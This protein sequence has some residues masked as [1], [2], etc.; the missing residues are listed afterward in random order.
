MSDDHTQEPMI[1][2][3]KPDG[4]SVRVP[5][6][7]LQKPAGRDVDTPTLQHFHTAT[8]QPLD[9]VLTNRPTGEGHVEQKMLPPEPPQTLLEES[10]EDDELSKDLG[11]TARQHYNTQTPPPVVLSDTRSTQN[12]VRST[13]QWSAIDHASPLTETLDTQTPHEV[14]S[15]RGEDQVAAFLTTMSVSI[16]PE[17]RGRTIALLSSFLKGIRSRQQVLGYAVK[18]VEIGGLQLSDVEA[19]SLVQQAEEY[20]HL[21]PAAG[22]RRPSAPFVP[23]EPVL[24]DTLLPSTE[25]KRPSSVHPPENGVRPRMSDIIPPSIALAQESRV[26]IDIVPTV[27]SQT[28]TAESVGPVE[29]I[30]TF[31]RDD[32]RRLNVDPAQAADILLL[33]MQHVSEESPVLGLSVRRAWFLCPLYREYLRMLETSLQNSFSVPDM[34][35]DTDALTSGE[36]RALLDVNRACEEV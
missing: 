11:T 17:L 8:P 30:Q 7:S 32:F 29:E 14:S 9:D 28:T 13:S 19:E 15:I 33:Q 21:R 2:V 27:A 26:P 12:A 34:A 23:K 4:T 35:Q 18:P 36:V 20:F 1:L 24:V 3:K 5:L 16:K 10:Y 31:T 22:A 25:V 6:S